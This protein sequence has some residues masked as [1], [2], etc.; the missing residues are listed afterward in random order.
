MNEGME[1][2]EKRND[3]LQVVA[4]DMFKNALANA[5]KKVK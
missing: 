1:F 3:D 2:D 5:K 4:K